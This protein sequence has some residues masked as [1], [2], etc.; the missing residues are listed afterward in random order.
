MWQK[1]SFFF[2]F[3]LKQATWNGMSETE[4][5]PPNL[6][7]ALFI[8]YGYSPIDNELNLISQSLQLHPHLVPI[9][10]Q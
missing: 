1:R 6:S 9:I 8:E 7:H 5:K 4:Q 2:F 10:A 3:S